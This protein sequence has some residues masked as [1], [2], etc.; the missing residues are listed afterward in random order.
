MTWMMDRHVCIPCIGL[1]R[2]QPTL[3]P[4]GERVGL[5]LGDMILRR[6][7]VNPGSCSSEVLSD[8]SAFWERWLGLILTLELFKVDDKEQMWEVC[9]FS[10]V[11]LGRRPVHGSFYSSTLGSSQMACSVVILVWGQLKESAALYSYF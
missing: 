2:V 11:Y 3:C 4:N 10:G 8:N 6:G 5:F 7:A 9:V 1:L